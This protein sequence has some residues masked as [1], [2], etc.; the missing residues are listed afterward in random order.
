MEE[1]QTEPV[2]DVEPVEQDGQEAETKA[3]TQPEIKIDNED[4]TLSSMPK[5]ADEYEMDE[6]ITSGLAYDE[7]FHKEFNAFAFN[8][9]LN[10]GQY[11]TIVDFWEKN[12]KD[13]DGDV[14]K[15]ALKFG[16]TASRLNLS[17]EFVVKLKNFLMKDI[18]RSRKEMKKVQAISARVRGQEGSE[19]RA[20]LI[21]AVQQSKAYKTKGVTDSERAAHKEAVRVMNELTQGR[22]PYKN[23]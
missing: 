4:F 14:D 19:T 22:N 10:Q 16:K 8:E 6:A 21:S 18:L 17:A 9:N 15:L 3:V 12:A 11:K 1:L 13:F 7:S 5:S 23:K 20:A 2:V